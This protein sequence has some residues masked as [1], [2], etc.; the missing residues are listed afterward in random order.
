MK[1]TNAQR[2]Q[3]TELVRLRLPAS[4]LAQK[5]PGLPYTNLDMRSIAALER[6]GLVECIV[7]QWRPPSADRDHFMP[8]Y[9]P[10]SAGRAIVE[11]EPLKAR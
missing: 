4:Y 8:T 9:R 1:L 5:F 3:L 7:H 6:R 10:T 2:A 11:A